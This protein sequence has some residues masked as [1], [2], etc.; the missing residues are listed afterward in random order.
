MGITGRNSL[1]IEFMGNRDGFFDE[2]N[3]LIQELFFFGGE[4][5]I[6]WRIG[7]V[8]LDRFFYSEEHQI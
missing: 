7:K 4:V 2:F 5:I 8:H 1:F 3:I 6:F